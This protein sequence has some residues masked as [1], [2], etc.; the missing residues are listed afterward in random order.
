MAVSPP[1]VLEGWTSEL[2]RRGF[3]L[4]VQRQLV[5]EAVASLGRATPEDIATAVQRTTP[6][7]NI[8][9]VYRTLE[10]LEQLGII[11]HTHL[12]HGAPAYSLAIEQPPVHLVCSACGGVEDAGPEL[13]GP[14]AAVLRE[15]HGFD[16]DLGHVALTGLCSACS[17]G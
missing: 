3:R 9:T 10:M 4:T 6:M 8:S 17:A 12:G 2:R 13:L 7:L 5:L 15:Q 16:L 1:G 14:V 11:R